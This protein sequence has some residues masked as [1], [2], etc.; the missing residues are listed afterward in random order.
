MTQ[1]PAENPAQVPSPA[2]GSPGSVP[3]MAAPGSAPINPLS[4][5]VDEAA[6]MLTAAGGKKVTPEMVQADI[7][8]GAPTAPGGRINLVHYAA[9]L[10][11][12]VQASGT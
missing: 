6:R 11:R 4:L 7:N 9:W 8:A 10:I 5:T 12:E 2:P 3:G 1:D